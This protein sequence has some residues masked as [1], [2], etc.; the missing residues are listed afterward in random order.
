MLFLGWLVFQMAN[1]SKNIE[2]TKKM[3]VIFS[4]LFNTIQSIQSIFQSILSLIKFNE[5]YGKNVK[6]TLNFAKLR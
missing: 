6:K 2:L 4:V 1:L 3:D 5:Q